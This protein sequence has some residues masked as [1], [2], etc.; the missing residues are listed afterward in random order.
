MFGVN[1]AFFVTTWRRSC[2]SLDKCVSCCGAGNLEL[3]VTVHI[4]RGTDEARLEARA[5]ARCIGYC[6]R[7]YSAKPGVLDIRPAARR[8]YT[9]QYFCV[10]H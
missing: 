2:I 1:P 8:Y 7:M 4:K 5:T 9:V 6:S 3:A 10:A